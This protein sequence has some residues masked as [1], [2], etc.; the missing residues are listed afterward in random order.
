MD[1]PAVGVREG[2]EVGPSVSLVDL[3]WRPLTDGAPRL[4]HDRLE[5]QALLV[6]ATELHLR[7]GVA[8][9]SLITLN[10][11]LF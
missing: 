4:A 7:R 5:A 6:L 3:H 1:L 11:S 8:S 9:L 10:G 2:V